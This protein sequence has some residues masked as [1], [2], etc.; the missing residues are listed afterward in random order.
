MQGV[1][2]A[3]ARRAGSLVRRVVG[4]GS[5]PGRVR[6]WMSATV[7]VAVL[8]GVLGALGIGRRDTS[9]GD[10]AG[11]A[12]QLI[13]VQGVQVS[14]VRADALASE[15]YLRGGVEDAATRAEYVRELERV[16]AGL[17]SVGNQVLPDEAARLAAVSAQLGEYSG[18][19]EQARANNRQGYPAG[20]AYLRAAN[21]TMLEMVA[22]L[23][24]VEASLRHQV[25]D[26]LDRADKA[27]AWLHLFGWTLLLLV[28]A[29][30]AWLAARFRRLLNLP[31][32]VA[33]VA[34]F[35][36]LLAAARV[37]GGAMT[38]AEAATAGALQQADLVAQARAAGFDARAQE[39]LTLINRGN[40]ADNEVKWEQAADNADSALSLLCGQSGDCDLLDSF[41][42]YEANYVTVRSVDDNGDWD[43]AVA[44]SLSS[45]RDLFDAFSSSSD[46][47][48]QARI[49]EATAALAASSDGLAAMRVL[50]FLAG[51]LVAALALAGYGQ[52]LREYR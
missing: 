44:N 30:S 37:Q 43:A 47:V 7:V 13:D 17:V 21:A 46:E 11:A 15:N 38:D 32:A 8:F 10:A 52:R 41:S 50:V 31:M 24:D 48:A 49:D 22:T 16:S 28:V 20:A 27:G 36:V 33:A 29:G 39:F 26:N 14:L 35:V 12:R 5:T 19:I 23:R 45:G 51:L 6:L 25:N 42:F 18:L 1:R 2:P 9:L 34:V 40:G 4:G 3:L